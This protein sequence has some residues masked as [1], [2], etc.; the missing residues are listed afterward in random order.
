MSS[1]QVQKN[2]TEESG[3]NE[4]NYLLHFF[5]GTVV[6]SIPSFLNIVKPFFVMRHAWQHS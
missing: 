2:A 6:L 4:F 1:V 5:A 3:V